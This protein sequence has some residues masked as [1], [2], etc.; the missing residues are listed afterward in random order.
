MAE[1]EDREH[2]IPIRKR[3]LVDLLCASSQLPEAD[4]EPFRQFCQIL[5]SIY[6]FEYHT[7][8]EDL[9]HAYAPFDPDADTQTLTVLGPDEKQGRLDGLFTSFISL[10]E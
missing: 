2:Y 6:H 9:K 4:R 3:E 8:L 1:Y 10:L 7:R 5:T